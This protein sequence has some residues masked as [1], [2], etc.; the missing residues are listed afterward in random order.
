M[1]D[2]QRQTRESLGAAVACVLLELGVGLKV[3]SKVGSVG[4]GATTLRAGERPLAGVCPQVPLKQ[5]RP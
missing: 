3:G 5:P 4:E 2:K 1:L